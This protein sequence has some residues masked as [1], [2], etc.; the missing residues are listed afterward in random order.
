MIEI[1]LGNYVL[2]RLTRTFSTALTSIKRE[3]KQQ[4]FDNTKLTVKWVSE[5]GRRLEHSAHDKMHKNIFKTLRVIK[6][7][8][9]KNVRQGFITLSCSYFSLSQNEV[10]GE[11]AVYFN[12]LFFPLLMTRHR[13]SHFCNDMVIQVS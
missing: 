1:S 13:C 10:I 12:E 8:L 5:C 11:I 4:T 2:S 6:C 7:R 9:H 3:N